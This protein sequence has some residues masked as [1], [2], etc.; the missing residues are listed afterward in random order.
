MVK[1]Q[2]PVP[3]AQ[4]IERWPPEPDAGVQVSPGTLIHFID[5]LLMKLLYKFNVNSNIMMMIYFRS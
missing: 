5:I 1:S 2:K 4:R 3:V